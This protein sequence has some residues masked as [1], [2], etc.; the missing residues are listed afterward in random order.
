MYRYA[1]QGVMFCPQ[2]ISS[3]K[4]G[5][6]GIPPEQM[7]FPGFS[8]YVILNTGCSCLIFGT[9]ASFKKACFKKKE[10]IHFRLQGKSIDSQERL[11]EF[12]KGIQ[13]IDVFLKQSEITA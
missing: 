5:S 10:K 8:G 4:F 11:P 12:R 6:S 2:L 9:G 1:A 7:V 3:I 13:F